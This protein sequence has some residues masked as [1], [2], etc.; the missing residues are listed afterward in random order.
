MSPFLCRVYVLLIGSTNVVGHVNHIPRIHCFGDY[1]AIWCYTNRLS[2]VLRIEGTLQGSC[3]FLDIPP[4]IHHDPINGRCVIPIPPAHSNH[5]SPLAS[6]WAHICHTT[7][8]RNAI[9][10]I[11]NPGHMTFLCFEV[12][13]AVYARPGRKG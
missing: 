10:F 5:V 6:N 3:L 7:I 9:N 8:H 2:R 12:V 11:S 1:C 4:G 13:L